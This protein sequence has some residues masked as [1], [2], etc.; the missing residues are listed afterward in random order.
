MQ[1]DVIIIG[2]GSMGMAAGYYL[3]KS[4]KKTLLLDSFNSPHNKGSHHGET[5]IIRYAYGEG[6]EYVPFVLR[7]QELWNELERD[8]G[9]RLFVQTGV[10]NVGNQAS[11]F[12]QNIISSAEK[13]SLPLDIMDSVE[14]HNRWSGITLPND[15]I[16]C[17]EPTSGVLKCEES[18]KAFQELAELHGA[19][20]L[21]NSRV[22]EISIHG[23]KV[24]VK[25]EDQAFHSDALVISAG[26]W[27]GNLLSMLDLDIPLTPVRKTFAWFDTDEENYNQDCFPAFAFE[28]QQGLYY[29]FPS[30]DGVGLKV[31]RHDGGIQT[32]PDEIMK[33]F[34][35]I[36]EDEGDLVQFL[37]QFIPAT[38]ELKY[39]KTCMYT[40]TPDEKFV[41]DLHPKYPNVAIAAG[42]SGHGFKFSSAVGQA[43]SNL[44]ISGSNDID[45]SQ[46]SI[47]RFN[48]LKNI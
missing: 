15:F 16:G 9:K 19:T 25:T 18:I 2:A 8:T 33:G 29:G 3:S 7:A 24:S 12:M 41:I 46:F 22:R 26:A 5:R 13:Y 39:G 45:I 17:F 36:A 10:L 21:T 43:L 44:I 47:T 11:N 40:L 48:N 23:E 34:G 38:G 1:Y 14:V 4:G 31:G 35:D 28:T 32:N 20:I 27:S 42:F 30:I 37:D 6:E